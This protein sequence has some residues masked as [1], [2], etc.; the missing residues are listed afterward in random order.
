MAAS[1]PESG[2]PGEDP[3]RSDAGP[4]ASDLIGS[5]DF[6][7]RLEAARRRRAEVMAR[8][9]AAAESPGRKDDP[10]DP[11]AGAPA[12][13]RPLPGPA[14]VPLPRPAAPGPAEA[15]AEAEPGRSRRAVTAIV[16][17]AIGFGIGCA[18]MVVVV[19]RDFLGTAP[20]PATIAET[21]EPRAPSGRAAEERPSPPGAPAAE[22]GSDAA[23]ERASAETAE[24]GAA[25]APDA[26]EERATPDAEAAED[27][28]ASA[29]REEAAT[30]DAP[31][32]TTAPDP[33]G[34]APEVTAGDA[35]APAGE[36]SGLEPDMAGGRAAA[37]EQSAPP[38]RGPAPPFAALPQSP[39]RLLGRESG[40]LSDL[41]AEMRAAGIEDVSTRAVDLVP[42]RSAVRFYRAG[43][44][45]LAERLAQ[46]FGADLQDL[47]SYRPAPEAAGIEV[48]LAGS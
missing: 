30:P 18:L 10:G 17:M 42:A 34:P 16:A 48:W 33:P 12:P 7:T 45:A 38:R 9:G 25:P 32:E 26:P 15:E 27:R 3:A 41:A 35:P 14:P 5:E 43:D 2:G 36:P 24:M 29:A 46:R 47:T 1:D 8:K 6:Q 20:E 22:A 23:E 39:V 4:T 40:R 37:P 21:P 28:A 11:K 31:G 44:R 13:E 19:G